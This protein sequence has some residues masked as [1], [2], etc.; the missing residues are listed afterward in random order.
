MSWIVSVLIWVALG[1]VAGWLASLIMK[2]GLSL[3]WCIILGIAGSVVG[4]FVAQLLDI[5]GGGLV[6]FLIAVAGACLLLLI[7]RILRKA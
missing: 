7:A 4:G 2:S 3:V 1:A 5:G 6:Q